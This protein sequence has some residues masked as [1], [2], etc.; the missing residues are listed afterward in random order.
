MSIN[1]IIQKSLMKR[2]CYQTGEIMVHKFCNCRDWNNNMRKID[3][4]FTFAAF[5]GGEDKL[6]GY[7]GKIF[8]YCPWCGKKLGNKDEKK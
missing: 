3:N 6:N 5:H 1:C 4:V 8:E 7:D 2:D